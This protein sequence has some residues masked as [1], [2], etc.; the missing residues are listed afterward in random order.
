LKAKQW[1]KRKKKKEENK[2]TK[3]V[4]VNSAWNGG[5]YVKGNLA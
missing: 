3:M 1:K 2:N 5:K 4:V